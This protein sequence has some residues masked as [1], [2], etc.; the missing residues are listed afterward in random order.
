MTIIGNWDNTRLNKN[1]NIFFTDPSPLNNGD[2]WVSSGI[3]GVFLNVRVAGITK[4]V[5]LA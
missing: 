2:I 3:S 1:T 4:S 5:E